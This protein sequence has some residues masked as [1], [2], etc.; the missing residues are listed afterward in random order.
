MGSFIYLPGIFYTGIWLQF[1]RL[2][3]STKQRVSKKILKFAPLT[4][5]QA[6]FKYAPGGTLCGRWSGPS[7]TTGV[8]GRKSPPLPVAALLLNRL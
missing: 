6:P 1:H 2:I 3:S 8:K 7:C 4:S 5:E